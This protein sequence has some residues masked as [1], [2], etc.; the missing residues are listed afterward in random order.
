MPSTVLLSIVPI[1]R[2]CEIVGF[3]YQVKDVANMTK[4]KDSAVNSSVVI[5]RP[6]LTR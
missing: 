5:G 4:E 3:A 6:I 1:G 2:G